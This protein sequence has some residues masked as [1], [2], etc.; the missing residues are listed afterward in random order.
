M[1]EQSPHSLCSCK[2][3]I[4]CNSCSM[5][6]S[7]LPDIYARARGPL[8]PGASVFTRQSKVPVLLLIIPLG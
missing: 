3:S 2:T 6:T 5:G 4:L 8:D 1:I 7:D